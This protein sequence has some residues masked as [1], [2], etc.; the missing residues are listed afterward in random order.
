MIDELVKRADAATE[1]AELTTYRLLAL[2]LIPPAEGYG[3]ANTPLVGFGPAAAAEDE[4]AVN[5]AIAFLQPRLD[6]E[7]AAGLANELT[8]SR[9]PDPTTTPSSGNG[10]T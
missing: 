5:Q 7:D 9:E 3:E 2:L 10:S 8:G 6:V 1:Q 4:D